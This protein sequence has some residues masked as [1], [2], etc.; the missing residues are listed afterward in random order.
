MSKKDT[1]CPKNTKINAKNGTFL[2]LFDQMKI[3]YGCIFE[4]CVEN[5]FYF[6]KTDPKVML[7]QDQSWRFMSWFQSQKIQKNVP[8]I[9]NYS[10]IP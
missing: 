4:K 3:S 5:V 8:N 7:Y 6:L 10:I 1:K 9:S 2:N